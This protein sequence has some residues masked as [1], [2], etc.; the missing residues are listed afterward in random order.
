M[1]NPV[2]MNV[3]GTSKRGFARNIEEFVGL[4]TKNPIMFIPNAVL[5]SQ[6]YSAVN[7]VHVYIVHL[8]NTKVNRLV[9]LY[10]A[11]IGDNKH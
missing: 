2:I 11:K 9:P 7:R 10:E 6:L 8:Y 4:S 1:H 3:W 5:T